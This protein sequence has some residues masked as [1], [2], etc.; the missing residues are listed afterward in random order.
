MQKI[1]N[2]FK[3]DKKEVTETEVQGSA[4]KPTTVTATVTNLPL[5]KDVDKN[6]YRIH[7]CT[8]KV[9]VFIALILLANLQTW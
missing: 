3:K 6:A 4:P 9:N 7:I 5:I 8:D 2:F 1:K